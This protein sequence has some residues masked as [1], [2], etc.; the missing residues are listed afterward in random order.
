MVNDSRMKSLSSSVSSFASSPPSST[1]TVIVAVF[2]S[3]GSVEKDNTP[4]WLGDVKS[5]TRFLTKPGLSEVAV[6]SIG[7]LSW[8]PAVIP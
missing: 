1:R 4:V 3:D 7:W 8:P 2:P 6:T 5:T